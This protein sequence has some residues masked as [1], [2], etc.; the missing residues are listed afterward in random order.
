[1]QDIYLKLEFD[2]IRGAVSSYARTERGKA[3]ALGMS[4]F[5]DEDSLKEEQTRLKEM[6]GLEARYGR[7]PLGPSADL[8]DKVGIAKKG[9]TLEPIDFLSIASDAR[10]GKEARAFFRSAEGAPKLQERAA[11]IPDLSALE[12]RI[13]RVVAPDLSIYDGASAKLRSI[14]ASK[15]RLEAETRRKLGSLISENREY[16]TDA[17]LTIKNG[18]YVM[19][20]SN[21]Y[22]RKV[23]GII[24]DVSNSGETAFIEPEAIVELNNRMY[25]LLNEEREEIRRILSEL[26]AEVAASGEGVLKE[27]EE[28]GYLDFLECK[29]LYGE[30][31]DGHV[32]SSNGEGEISLMSARH[33]L[34]DKAKAVPNDFSL[35]KSR[36]LIVISGPNAG[37]KTVALKTVGLLSLMNECGLPVSAAE[38]AIMPFFDH[39]YADIGDSQSLVDNLST[40][41]GHM[42][43]V[44]EILGVAGSDDLVLLDEL[45]TGTSPREG[46][47]IAYAVVKDLL[48][49]GP[50]TMVSSHFE[51]LKAFALAADGAVNASMAFDE[52]TLEPTYRLRMGLP[53][54][55]YGLIVA[56]RFGLSEDVAEEAQKYLDENQ[57]LSVPAAIKKLQA[58]TE[59]ADKA[60]EEAVRKSRELEAEKSAL[61][62][63][64]ARLSKREEAFN[65]DL[66][67]RKERL[68]S[69]YEKEMDG[70]LRSV[71][72]G[73]RKLH[74]VIDAK[75]RLE[76][77]H[78]EKNDEVYDD[79]VA[80]GDYVNV[81]SAFLSGR[82]TRIDGEKVTIQTKEGMS[83]LTKKG[84]V[85]RVPEPKEERK[86][87]SGA[88]LDE[89]VSRQSLPM[90]LN[91]IGL[92]AEEARIELDKYL[93]ECRIRGYKRVRIIHGYGSGA[94]RNMVREYCGSH[95]DFIDGYEPAGEHEGGGGASI[96]R[97]K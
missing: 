50:L 32:A 88:S 58:A 20:V 73:D 4:A 54:E 65:E 94:L 34:I 13:N 75:K 3:L 49:K 25:L 35:N 42:A 55:S 70:I 66:E 38:G 33:P 21:T 39:I 5:A 93:D 37:G 82:V 68:L 7:L 71:S 85:V 61:A 47:A 2:R 90:E 87:M 56:R 19:P 1:M 44:S 26:S 80:V 11:S 46:E 63:K 83:V 17:T 53:G 9:G 30:A 22:K 6:M 23:R 59:E 57:E 97:L 27:N 36:R 18:H 28:I 10:I 78:E 41:S 81:P 72:S 91:L 64:E 76:G 48:K 86:A 79:E 16:L 31:I 89:A 12:G 92:R 60:K 77:L 14:R 8:R 24:Q 52:K 95:K 43:N 45:G 84:K 67:G 96:V 15:K 62:E 74:E 69:E 51:G 29:A 40:F